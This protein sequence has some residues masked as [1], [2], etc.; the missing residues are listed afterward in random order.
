MDVSSTETPDPSAPSATL[1]AAAKKAGASLAA[2]ARESGVEID[3]L[4]VAIHGIGD[5]YRQATIQSVVTRFGYHFNFPA[6]VP[7]GSFYS[8]TGQVN[9]FT[10]KPLPDEQATLASIG[11]VEAY[12]ADIPRRVQRRGYIIQE[13]KAWAR[14]IVERVRARYGEAAHQEFGFTKEDFRAASTVLE[15]M[16]DT[17]A[18][19]GNLLFLAEKAGVLQFDLDTMLTSYLGDV[20]IVADFA[21]YRAKILAQFNEVL[22]PVFDE[23]KPQQTAPDIY[24]IAHSEGTVVAF[25]ALLQA[26]GKQTSEE[27]RPAWVDHVRG[28]MTIGSPI[29]KHI[30]LWPSIWEAMQTPGRK[31][32]AG[33]IK[34]RNYYDYGDPVGFELDTTRAWMHEHG[35]DSFEFR[36]QDRAAGIQDDFGFSRYFLPGAA[37]NDYWTDPD[38]FGHFLQTVIKLEPSKGVGDFQQPPADRPLAKVVSYV[39]PYGLTVAILAAGVY[40][41]FKGLRGFL[42]NDSLRTSR[43]AAEDCLL[44]VWTR[45]DNGPHAPPL[46]KLFDVMFNVAG[47]TSLLAGMTLAARIPRLTRSRYWEKMAAALFVVGAGFYV[48]LVDAPRRSWLG[49]H[50]VDKDFLAKAAWLPTGITLTVAAVICLVAVKGGRMRLR[51]KVQ[52]WF[53]GMRPLLV[54][55]IVIVAAIVIFRLAS[56]DKGTAAPLWPLLLGGAAFA[57]LWWLAA[58]IFDLVF[59]WHRYIR[60]ATLQSHLRTLAARHKQ[61][62]NAKAE[63]IPPTRAA[64]G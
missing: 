38:V 28:F 52:P 48:L 43:Q 35:W 4:V 7:L 3:K 53:H 44:V 20:Q 31:P 22:G 40:L 46:G 49:F 63:A 24:I 14:T 55:G 37:H 27:G 51:P 12:W 2:K 13:S 39:L 45:S 60:H 19:L 18:V 25:M 9:A 59:V 16:I 1:G 23:L 42:T 64:N 54:P 56:A 15:E 33:R 6:T 41:M 21:N 58:L 62:A 10:L 8:L 17:I 32:E 36:N 5:Q 57:Y 30:I 50:A 26:L 29:D 61:H 47:I 11:F 34:W